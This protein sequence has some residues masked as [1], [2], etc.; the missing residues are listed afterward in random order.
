MWQRIYVPSSFYLPE[1]SNQK[2]MD[3][4]EQMLSSVTC[5]PKKSELRTI[6]WLQFWFGFQVNNLKSENCANINQFPVLFL[7]LM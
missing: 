7:C 1:N 5:E 6:L 4:L 2:Q 3:H